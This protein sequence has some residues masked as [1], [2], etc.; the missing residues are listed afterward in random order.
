[1]GKF[2]TACIVIFLLWKALPGI[3]TGLAI[4]EA[5]IEERQAR[6]EEYLAKQK[7]ANP[8]R[9]RYQRFDA[10]SITIPTVVPLTGNKHIENIDVKEGAVRIY[11]VR[12]GTG[13]NGGI[14]SDGIAYLDCRMKNVNV[15]WSAIEQA[16]E[17]HIL[18]PED[19][20]YQPTP[21]PGAWVEI[22]WGP[23]Q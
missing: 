15:N 11:W 16:D 13:N 10:K 7:A 19:T 5:N 3:K 6:R 1:M 12:K 23:Q 17:L 20:W 8:P 2:I 4:R 18:L 9:E 22:D 21:K 14:R